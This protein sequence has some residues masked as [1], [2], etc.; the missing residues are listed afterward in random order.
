MVFINSGGTTPTGEAA[1]IYD[2]G[3]NTLDIDNI[4][5]SDEGTI[6]GGSPPYAFTSDPDTGWG[7][8]GG[9]PDKVAFMVGGTDIWTFDA[10]VSPD[11]VTP[12]APFVPPTAGVDTIGSGSVIFPSEMGKYLVNIT[13]GAVAVTL[14][15][16]MAIGSQFSVVQGGTGVLTISKSGTETINGSASVS[17]GTQYI[18]VTFYKATS[19]AWY[20]IGPVT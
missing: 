19:S 4:E 12:E 14:K 2:D 6:P 3:T 13:G 7:N 18:G 9:D 11:Q 15:D 20:A 10:D 16:S 8:A 17:L 5:V 1:F